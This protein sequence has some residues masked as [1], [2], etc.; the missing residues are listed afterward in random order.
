MTHSSINRY[1][2][3]H[4]DG[5]QFPI[6]FGHH[7]PVYHGSSYDDHYKSSC[8][9]NH[10][11]LYK[12]PI[13]R[14]NK[15]KI[16][17]SIHSSVSNDHGTGHVHGGHR[18]QHNSSGR[19][20]GWNNNGLLSINEKETMKVLNERLASYLEKVHSLEQE[21]GAL[22][23]KICEWYSN[24]AP[25]SLPDFSQYMMI[26]QELQSKITQ[27][28]TENASIFLHA[29]NAMLAAED[30]RIKYEIEAFLRNNTEED[31]CVLRQG[32]GD[33]KRELQNLN[34]HV[35]CLQ[36]ELLQLKQS[37]EETSELDRDVNSRVEQM[38][39]VNNE[40]IDLKLLGQKLEI[41][42]ENQIKTTSAMKGSLAE[43]DASFGSQLSQLQLLINNVQDQLSQILAEFK[44][45]NF[46]YQLLMDQKTH[47]EKEITKYKQLIDTQATNYI[48][49]V[50]HG[51]SNKCHN[52]SQSGHYKA[53]S[54]HGASKKLSSHSSIGLEHGSG[55]VGNLR[56]HHKSSSSHSHG[57]L[58]INEK[59]TM[60]FLNGRLASY[61]EKVHSLEQE[62]SQ[63]ERK[64]CE[65]YANNAPSSLPDSSQYFRTIHEL[66]NQVASASVDN[67][68]IALQIDNG[69]QA[70]DDF[71]SKY[72]MEKNLR[73][74]VE[75]DIGALHKALG[76]LNSKLQDLA[77]QVQCLQQEILQ[78][79]NNHT[80]EVNV[81][82]A[83][84]G[85]RVNVEMNAAPSIDLN[86]VLS[87][88]REEYE[89]LMERNLREV[90]GMFLE[91]SAE[92]DREVSSGSEQMQSVNNELIDLKH[93]VQ[94]LEIELQSQLSLKSALEGT[95]AETEANF[96][97]QLS[98]L[99]CIIDNVESQLSQI[100][101]DLEQQNHKYQLLMDQKTHLERE[102]STYRHLMDGH[103]I[104]FSGH[105]SSGGFH[106]SKC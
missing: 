75:A 98:Q 106:H 28:T 85:A 15:K 65:W 81:L 26:I 58:S 41:E 52:K 9:S 22:E 16:S 74:N 8:R 10:G 80:E 86:S 34:V 101:S 35:N 71:R 47:L 43:I 72:E 49:S 37:H 79:K 97:S 31:V 5:R 50:H 99:Q 6:Y 14:R 32:L 19:H 33:L 94:T 88:V 104:H 51:S 78:L 62:N 39:S 21:N 83:Q 63:L 23:T 100:R 25:S 18:Y 13:A 4:D 44:Y 73:S 29:D 12:A 24:N 40:C 56:S 27:L 84:L 96:R 17:F 66:Q 93:S 89:N 46:K 92:L 90:E 38:Q 82:R 54:H 48:S 76:Q 59:E 36:E 64:I 67:A 95:L 42:L 57:L 77:I 53:S 20:S 60:Q 91:R 105:S 2:R 70:A 102:I 68:R 1:M 3:V 69:Q 103:D 55:S 30:L 7:S 45:L 11:D 61:L 87:E